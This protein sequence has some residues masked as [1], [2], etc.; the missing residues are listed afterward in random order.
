MKKWIAFFLAM[1]LL[2]PT[3]LAAEEEFPYHT[4]D[5]AREE[6]GRAAELGLI[7]DPYDYLWNL[8]SAILR[9]DF[10]SNA[11]ALV[12]KGFGVDLEGYTLVM[13]YRRQAESEESI[14]SASSSIPDKT[15][16]KK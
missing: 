9:E 10:A 4:S 7:Y 14:F 11:A 15:E 1:F 2:A 5:W 8:Q 6:V 13:N 12:S 16:E 3:A